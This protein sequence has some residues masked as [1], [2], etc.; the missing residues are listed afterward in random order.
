MHTTWFL[1][2]LDVAAWRAL[3]LFKYPKYLLRTCF[4]SILS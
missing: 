3:A 4:L 2:A 1:V